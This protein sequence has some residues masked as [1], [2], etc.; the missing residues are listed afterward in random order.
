MNYLLVR[1][2]KDGSQW[3]TTGTLKRISKLH[4]YC[5]GGAYKDEI[6]LINPEGIYKKIEL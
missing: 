1:T 5:D 3:V 4:S 6:Y 2:Y